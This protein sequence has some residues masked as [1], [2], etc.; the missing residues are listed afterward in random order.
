MS[1]S[2]RWTMP[3]RAMPAIE[4]YVPGRASRAFTSVPRQW[5]G[6]GM[7]DQ[8]RGL[9]DD[10]HIGVLVGGDHRDRRVGLQVVRRLG[11]GD[12]EDDDGVAV[13]DRSSRAAGGPR[14]P[15]GARRRSAAAR[16]T[17][18]GRS[19]RRRSG[20]RAGPPGPC[21]MAQA[22]L[23]RLDRAAS[24]RAPQV[25]P[26][27]PRPR[28]RRPRTS[29]ASGAAASSATGAQSARRGNTA[30]RMNSD[31]RRGDRGVGDVERVKRQVPMPMSTKSTTEP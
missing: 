15:P 17:A 27:R 20:R 6:A 16:T 3:G 7:D 28:R 12:I 22:A 25:G 24:A 19:G 29:S 11:L 14:R 1:R 8:P 9:V 4:P 10:Q 5:P 21:G 30:S 18:T 26:A 2:S 31:D 13:D 23:A